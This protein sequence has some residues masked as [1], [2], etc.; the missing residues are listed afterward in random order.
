[1]KKYP[2]LT[3]SII[4]AATA[5]IGLAIP[6]SNYLFWSLPQTRINRLIT[7]LQCDDH[8]GVIEETLASDP[9]RRFTNPSDPW[10]LEVT[11]LML[12]ARQADPETCRFLIDS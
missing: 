8:R 9:N 10:A 3:I 1:M 5:A 6:L 4:L 2:I 12:A 7:E 11:L